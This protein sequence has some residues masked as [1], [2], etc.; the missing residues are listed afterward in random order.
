MLFLNALLDVVDGDVPVGVTK[1]D[2]V[3]VLLSEGAARDTVL[4]L[5]DE[6]RVLGVFQCPEANESWL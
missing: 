1:S 3:L 5:E 6:F 4:G 2:P